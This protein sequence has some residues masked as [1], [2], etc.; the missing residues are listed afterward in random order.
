MRPHHHNCTERLNV[1]LSVST[2]LQK[3]TDHAVGAGAGI[4]LDAW[5]CAA[6][7]PKVLLRL[8]SK[9]SLINCDSRDIFQVTLMQ[10][11]T[12]ANSQLSRKEEE[13]LAE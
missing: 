8:N 9:R 13:F 4:T 11:I 10:T 6:M 12:I 3:K 2:V 7:S 5:Y 1:P